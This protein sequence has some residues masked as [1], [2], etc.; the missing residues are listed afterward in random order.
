MDFFSQYIQPLTSWFYTHP[1][2][3]LFVTFI[4]SM[5]ESLAIIGTLIPGTVSMTAI[6]ILAGSGI[7]RI[8]LTLLAA[9][10]GAI[11]GDGLSYTM[12]RYFSERLNDMWVFRRYPN[13]QVH[14]ALS[15]RLCQE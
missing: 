1:H 10:L 2:A 5:G 8:D 4:I 7:M 12:G 11:A 15:Y 14:Y 3:A 6:G 13:L 9:I